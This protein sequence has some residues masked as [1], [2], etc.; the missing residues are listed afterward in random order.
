[1]EEKRIG[2]VASYFSQVEVAAIDLE[3]PLAVG[4]TVHIK[5]TTTDFAQK[6]ES[7]Q[8]DRKPVQK[9]KKGQSIGIKVAERV[10]PNDLVYKA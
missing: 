5:G 8:I 2:K 10:R 1:M 7:M 4:D 3:G 6:V 9:A